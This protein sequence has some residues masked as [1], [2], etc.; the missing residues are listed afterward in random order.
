MK[1][2]D[3]LLKIGNNVLGGQRGA[4]LNR[5]TNTIDITTKLSDEW[6]EKKAGIKEWSVDCDG[7]VVIDDTAFEA[8]EAAYMN[9]TNV[10]VEMALGSIKYTGQ[11]VITSFPIEAPYDDEVSY[12]VT[13][14]GTGPLVKQ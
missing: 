5:S 11:A 14:E 4:T 9:G 2:V 8:L 13:L 7:L 6:S 10:T 3:V 12:S 1:G